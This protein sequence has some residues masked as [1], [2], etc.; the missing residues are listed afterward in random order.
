VIGRV[1]PRSLLLAVLPQPER[2]VLDALEGA[3]RAG[4]LEEVGEDSY[5]FVHDVIR[6]VV[7]V[8]L[9]LAR[10]RLLHRQVAMALERQPGTAE[11][12]VLAYHFREAGEQARTVVYLEQA[13]DRSA[14]QYAHAAAAA[15]YQDLVTYLERLGHD[16]D[17]AGALEK[18]GGALTNVTQ[19]DA[20][21]AALERAAVQLAGDLDRLGQVVLRM[22]W[23]HHARGDVAAG[24]ARLQPIAELLEVAGPSAILAQVYDALSGLL[25]EDAQPDRSMM[26]AE[27]AVTTA[28][29]VGERRI[30][31]AAEWKRSMLLLCLNCADEALQAAADAVRLAEEAD[32][33]FTLAETLQVRAWVH[34]ERGEYAEDRQCARRG[35]EIAERI[36]D[37]PGIIASR[38]RLGLSAFLTGDWPQARAWIEQTLAFTMQAGLTQGHAYAVPRLDLG[39]LRLAE[40]AWDEAAQLFEQ[41]LA[42]FPEKVMPTMQRVA[43]CQ[44]AER[45]VLAGNPAAART[46]LLPLLDRPGV[47][48]RMVAQYTLPVLAWAQLK[49]GEVDQAAATAADAIRRGRAGCCRLGLVQALWVQAQVLLAQERWEDVA[50]SL[51]EGLALARSMPYPHGEGRLLHVYGLLH[52]LKGEPAQAREWLDAALAIFTRLGARKDVEWAERD[53]AALAYAVASGSTAS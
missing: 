20:A 4:V 17:L 22:A 3:C 23:I 51:D 52:A 46:R 19:Y 36:G 2:Q 16:A 49:A 27:Q 38:M 28:R 53:L 31:A 7:E 11:V 30:Q 26:A 12:E 40:G 32:D 1:A 44:L 42:A 47:E 45:D 6:E 14:A 25:D 48:E 29:A 39:R 43:Q 37:V 5:G 24:L 33:P 15:Y 41:S 35:L 18:L 10:R 50:H 21:L 9:G 34:E 8:G 13:G